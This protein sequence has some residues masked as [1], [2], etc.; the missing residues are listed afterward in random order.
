MGSAECEFL[1][2]GC[3]FESVAL[4]DGYSPP[5]N[6]DEAR[7]SQLTQSGSYRFSMNSELAGQIRMSHARHDAVLGTF[8]QQVRKLRDQTFAGNNLHLP[9]NVS[10]SFAH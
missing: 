2:L 7:S 9:E 3:A 8:Y 5:F 1:F 10:A 6:L 4:K